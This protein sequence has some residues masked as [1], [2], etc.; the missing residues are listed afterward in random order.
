MGKFCV[1]VNV[2]QNWSVQPEE[3]NNNLHRI[4]RYEFSLAMRTVW[5]ET[6]NDALYT[7]IFYS[8]FK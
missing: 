3:Q 8:Y 7:C 1:S 5:H 2:D 4:C 6:G